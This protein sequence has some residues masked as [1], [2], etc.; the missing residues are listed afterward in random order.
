MCREDA[1]TK[2]ISLA[3]MYYEFMWCHSMYSRPMS[4]EFGVHPSI[5][6]ALAEFLHNFAQIEWVATEINKWTSNPQ[7]WLYLWFRTWFCRRPTPL[8][9]VH[10]TRSS[11]VGDRAFPVTQLVFGT[12]YGRIMSRLQHHSLSSAAAWRHTSLGAA[13][14]DCIRHSYCCAW[15]VT[16]SLSDTFVVLVTYLLTYRKGAQQCLSMF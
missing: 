15:E 2:L 10:R 3:C 11:T 14:P 8:L 7:N 1:R 13:F 4:R 12:V 5:I 6:H 9:I 16:L